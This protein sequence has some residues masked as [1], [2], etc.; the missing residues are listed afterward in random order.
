MVIF[1]FFLMSASFIK[2]FFILTWY[3]IKIQYASK[4]FVCGVSSYLASDFLIKL[5]SSLWSN[6]DKTQP[7][8]VS[9][10]SAETTQ[11]CEGQIHKTA[12]GKSS[13]WLSVLVGN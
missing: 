1:F 6:P 11:K 7:E 13:F 5:I 2:V 9:V 3:F 10:Q 12:K 4:T 8:K